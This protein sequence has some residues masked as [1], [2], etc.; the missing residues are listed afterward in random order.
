[1]L[2]DIVAALTIP[3]LP[4]WAGLVALILLA[5]VGLAFLL[6]PFSVF[7]LKGRIEAIEAQLDEIQADIRS[8]AQTMPGP[9]LRRPPAEDDWAEPSS[10]S[11]SAAD[12]APA[13][14]RPPTVPPAAWPD[15]G[16]GRSEPR[17]DWPRQPR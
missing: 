12:M 7:G 8:L 14:I 16:A 6:M 2:Q 10:P 13:R 15:R 5:I 9:A 4:N 17:L 1:M 11:V 3:G